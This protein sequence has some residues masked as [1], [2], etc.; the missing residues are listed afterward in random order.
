MN[1]LVVLRPGHVKH[2]SRPINH[3]IGCTVLATQPQSG[4][5]RKNELGIVFRLFFPDSHCKACV[6]LVLASAKEAHSAVVF[7][8]VPDVPRWIA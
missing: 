4:I 2:V 6:F 8:A 3:P 1:R 7:L 5:Q